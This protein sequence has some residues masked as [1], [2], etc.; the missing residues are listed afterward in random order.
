MLA[1]LPLCNFM[2]IRSAIPE[3]LVLHCTALHWYCTVLCCAALYWY[4]TVLCCAALH[5]YCTALYCACVSTDANT[6]RCSEKKAVK[7]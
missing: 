5:W 1:E 2:K 4:C 7:F 6:A 3:L